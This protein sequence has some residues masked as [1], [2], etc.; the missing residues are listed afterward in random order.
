MGAAEI[1]S[2]LTNLA[3]QHQVS[4]ST[5]NQAFSALLFLYR[6]VLNLEVKGLDDVVRAKT[7]VRLPVVLSPHE[8]SLVLK[9]LHGIPWLMAALM[10]GSGVRLLE[11][12]RVRVKDLD[13]PRQA[14][15]VRDGK[16]RK[17]RVTTLPARLA[18]P[19]NAHLEQLRARH[20]AELIAGRG[21]V[22][23][24]DAL[25]RKYPG[26]NTE[27]G[28][29][30]LFPAARLFVDATGHAVKYHLHETVQQHAFKEAV[31]VARLTKP[32][33]SHTMRHSFATHLLERGYDIRTIQ[34]LLGH[35]DVS[36]TMIYTHVLN[37]GGRAVQSPFD[38][39]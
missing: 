17:D 21:Q 10:Y 27:W 18:A 25:A 20:Q 22:V 36:T 6:V 11:C 24:P 15:T 29:Q 19:F 34:E 33:T 39:L 35:K 13:F 2:F 23:L 32:A 3:T 16:G 7:P 14:L 26:A 31:R 28:W 8:I 12:C 1:T 37:R 9:E 4:A 5:Q 30:W 38:D